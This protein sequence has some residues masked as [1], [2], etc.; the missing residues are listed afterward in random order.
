[1]KIILLILVNIFLIGCEKKCVDGKVYFQD[2]GVWY[3]EDA[4]CRN[5]KGDK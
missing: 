4:V 1:M 5:F 3:Q 2:N